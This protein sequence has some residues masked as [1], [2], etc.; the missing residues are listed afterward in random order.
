MYRGQIRR[1]R[2]SLL[3]DYSSVLGGALMR[4]RVEVAERAKRVEAERAN[5]IIS[6]F[7]ANMSH[8]LRTPLN[9]IIGFS[10]FMQDADKFKLN[11]DQ[12]RE[13]SGYIHSGSIKLLDIINDILEFSKLQGESVAENVQEFE[14]TG[15]L[16]DCIKALSS[17]GTTS[18]PPIDVNTVADRLVLKA[19]AFRL[20][21]I[22]SSIFQN[23]RNTLK[24]LPDGRHITVSA[25][26]RDGNFVTVRIAGLTDSAPC[27]EIWNDMVPFSEA[28]A[29]FSETEKGPGLGLSMTNALVDSQGGY[30]EIHRD[31]GIGMAVTVNLPRARAQD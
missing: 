22:F 18:V 14:L 15:L 10:N 11:Q 4:H 3:D 17:E 21:Q 6:Q 20:K 23:A 16:H 1:E 30:M 26:A 24:D 12:I 29:N 27:D 5:E 2:R 19:D 25:L 28:H 13:Y 31:P 7:I 8:E 9:A